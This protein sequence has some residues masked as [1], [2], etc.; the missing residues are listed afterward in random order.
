ML[1]VPSI[2]QIW[3]RNPA[4]D[5]YHTEIYKILEPYLK[6]LQAQVDWLG[7]NNKDDSMKDMIAMENRLYDTFIKK[8]NDLQKQ[9]SDIE[10]QLWQ[11]QKKL[12]S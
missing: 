7:S 2:M 3:V 5:N 12:K 1:K 8:I 4:K 9:I 11:Q 10:K 6:Q